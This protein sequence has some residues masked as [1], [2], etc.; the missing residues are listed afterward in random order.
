M[1]SQFTKKFSK[2]KEKNSQIQLFGQR[3]KVEDVLFSTP[4]TIS[5]SFITSIQTTIPNNNRYQSLAEAVPV[6][7]TLRPQLVVER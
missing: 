3:F 7:W 1:F 2:Q 4:F 5:T 6:D